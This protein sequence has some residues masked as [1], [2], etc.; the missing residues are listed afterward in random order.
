MVEVFS[1][2]VIPSRAVAPASGSEERAEALQR[3]RTV[4]VNCLFAVDAVPAATGPRKLARGSGEPHVLARPSM[5][6]HSGSAFLQA[7]RSSSGPRAQTRRRTGG[8]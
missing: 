4:D 1:R 7:G 5:N 6:L 8:G 2:A 3:L